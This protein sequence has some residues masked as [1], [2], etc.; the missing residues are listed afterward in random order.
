MKKMRKITIRHCP[1]NRNGEVYKNEKIFLD[2]D[3]ILEYTT[4]AIEY[5]KFD[6]R[7]FDKQELLMY[8]SSIPEIIEDLTK[9]IEG[10]DNK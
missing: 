8:L 6:G 10:G 9:K 4:S 3:A 5:I 1:R 2:L 7:G